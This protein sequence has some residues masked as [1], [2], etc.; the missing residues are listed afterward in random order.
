MTQKS[1]EAGKSMDKF[2]Q[3]VMKELRAEGK[4]QMALR[5]LE[6]GPVILKDILPP[7][8]GDSDPEQLRRKLKQGEITGRF[9][10]T[11]YSLEGLAKKGLFLPKRRTIHKKDIRRYILRTPYLKDPQFSISKFI[12]R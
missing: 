9:E 7:V 4:R 11:W 1:K 3:E 8:P 10:L 5:G 6:S 12:H 2:A